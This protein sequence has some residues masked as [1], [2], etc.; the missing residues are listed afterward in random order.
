VVD[1]ISSNVDKISF[2]SS[3]VLSVYEWFICSNVQ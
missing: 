2:V 1:A 3:A